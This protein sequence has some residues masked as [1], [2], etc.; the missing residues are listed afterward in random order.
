MPQIIHRHASAEEQQECQHWALWES[1]NARYFQYSY[2]QDVQFVVQSG[3]AVIHSATNAPVSIA[4]GSHVTVHR[5]V[6]GVWEINS[7]I[8][9]RYQYL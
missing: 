5:G 2:D 7:P 6:E 3:E 8:T 4:Q 9:N 1:A